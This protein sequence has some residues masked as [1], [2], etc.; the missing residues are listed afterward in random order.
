M[1]GAHCPH[2]A[3]END[4]IR[5]LCHDQRSSLTLKSVRGGFAEVFPKSPYNLVFFPD[6]AVGF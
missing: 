5:G 4:R 6:F 3:Y 2:Q 1:C